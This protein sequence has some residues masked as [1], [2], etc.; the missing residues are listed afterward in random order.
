[1]KL[2][3]F[4][5]G[6][7]PIKIEELETF[8]TKIG[9]YLPQEFKQFLLNHNGAY[10][11][12]DSLN[13]KEPNDNFEDGIPEE[14]QEFCSNCNTL[15]TSYNYKFY[16]RSTYFTEVINLE[17]LNEIFGITEDEN[18]P[19]KK[20]IY[21]LEGAGGSSGAYL[22][23]NEETYG[24]IYWSDQT[25][26]GIFIFIA[27]NLEEFLNSFEPNKDYSEDYDEYGNCI[28]E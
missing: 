4:K 28:L 7:K 18:N 27:N 17:S 24:K 6:F 2:K 23:L 1:M 12:Q 9:Y 11:H 10:C 5:E 25:H 16:N 15:H 20:F 3:I 22:S 8:E 21:F 14:I 19:G 26:D 13:F